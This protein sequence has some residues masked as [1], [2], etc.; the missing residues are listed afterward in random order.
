[1]PDPKAPAAAAAKAPAEPATN[2]SA[3][4][5]AALSTD[6]RFA[7]LAADFMAEVNAKLEALRA[8]FQTQFGQNVDPLHQDLHDLLDAQT[9]LGGRLEKVEALQPAAEARLDE[10][11][12]LVEGLPDKIAPK[13]Q[14]VIQPVITVTEQ[15][16]DDRVRRLERVLKSF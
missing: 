8:E 1:M 14:P 2:P 9:V 10:L 13:I 16:I 15:S 4:A 3:A 11:Q 7:A 5:P 6:E 12:T